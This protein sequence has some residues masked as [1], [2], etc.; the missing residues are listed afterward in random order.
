MRRMFAVAIALMLLTGVCFAGEKE[1]LQLR[2]ANLQLTLQLLQYQFK[3]AQEALKV[4]TNELAAMDAAEK[5]KEAK[6]KE[7]KK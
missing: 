6:P 3:E 2:Q 1:E 5:A 7:V 4:V